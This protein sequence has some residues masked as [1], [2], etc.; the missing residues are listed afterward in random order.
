[1][2]NRFPQGH[3]KIGSSFVVCLLSVVESCR[4][5]HIRFR[6]KEIDVLFISH[7]LNEKQLKYCATDVIYLHEICLML[8][9]ILKRENRYDLYTKAINCIDTRVELDLALFTEDI[10]SH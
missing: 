6:Y 8:T 7:L 1:M 9:N 3:L 2:H 10:W 5:R 4:A